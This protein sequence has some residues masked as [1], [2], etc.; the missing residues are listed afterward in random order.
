[1]ASGRTLDRA[2]EE[3]VSKASFSSDDVVNGARL[4]SSTQMMAEAELAERP[5]DTVTESAASTIRNL[6]GLAVL[7]A[8]PV[9][10][11]SGTWKVL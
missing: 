2:I 3:Y 10:V 11:L 9:A 4:T 1:M 7:A 8:L 6:E 5:L